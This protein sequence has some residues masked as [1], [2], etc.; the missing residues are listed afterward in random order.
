METR[1]PQ[2]QLDKLDHQDAMVTMA[3]SE[4]VGM[5]ASKES[6]DFEDQQELVEHPVLW[7]LLESLESEV[8]LVQMEEWVTKDP[9]ELPVCQGPQDKTDFQEPLEKRGQSEAR[10]SVGIVE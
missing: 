2:D 1:D 10:E 8:K 9:Q 3:R 4:S 7:E 6:Q 5:T